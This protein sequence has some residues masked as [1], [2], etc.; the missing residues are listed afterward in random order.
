MG[1]EVKAMTNQEADTYSYVMTGMSLEELAK[2][3]LVEF[4]EDD[5]KAG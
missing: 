1:K 5:K 2:K 3:I 4:N